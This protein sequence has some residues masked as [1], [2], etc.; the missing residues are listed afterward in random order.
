ML[1]YMTYVITACIL[2][3]FLKD[4]VCWPHPV[5]GI[6]K[7]IGWLEGFFLKFNKYPYFLGFS[8]VISLSV[9]IY[10]GVK[11][12]ISIPRVGWIFFIY[13]GFAGLAFGSLLR[14]GK[15]VFNAI[16][17]EDL[18]DAR[19]KLGYLVSRDTS[20]M[21]F[22]EVKK[23][24]IETMSENFNDGFLA[25]WFY[26]LIGGPS[27]LWVYKV[28]STFDSMWGYKVKHYHKLGF[29]A[30][31]LD[32]CLAYFP[33]RFSAFVFWLV[34][35]IN[36]NYFSLKVVQKEASQL[37]SPN[38]GWP[39]SA[40]AYLLGIELGGK[41]IY[42]DKIVNKPLLGVKGVYPQNI[43]LE[44]M[45]AFLNFAWGITIVFSLLI[46]SS[47]ILIFHYC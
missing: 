32:D 11:F 8:S 33:A 27:W 13:L 38:A 29:F 17:R 21:D 42:F 2:D 20:K 47:V 19:E 44:R 12:L 43:H 6:G 39:M 45:F 22:L 3:L 34:G 16:L 25:P 5:V 9:L 15:K 14:E 4:P 18:E 28:V 26:F 1:E 37:Q 31:K 41:N 40:M 35:I 36:E 10:Y 7:I 30:A 46:L 24:L 23:A